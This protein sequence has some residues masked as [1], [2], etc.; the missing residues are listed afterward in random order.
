MRRRGV[1]LWTIDERRVG[2]DG[3]GAGL[4]RGE[5]DVEG[6]ARR[7]RRRSSADRAGRRGR[8]RRVRPPGS[9]GRAPAA[10]GSWPSASRSATEKAALEDRPAPTGR[11]L[12]T[13]TVPPARRSAGAAGAR[14]PGRPRGNR[15]GVVAQGD[16]QRPA[17]ELVRV[18]PDQEAAG[19]RREGDLG[20]QV[21]GHR[22][23]EAAVV[24]GV[25]ADD[26]H[27]SGGTGRRHH[28][29]LAQA[30]RLDRRGRLGSRSCDD[31]PQWTAE[32]DQDHRAGRDRAGALHLHDA[33]R[34]R[35]AGPAPRAG[36]AGRGRAGRGAP[37]VG[38]GP[39]LGPVEPVTAV[40]RDRPQEPRRRRARARPGRAGGRADRG[41]PARCGRAARGRARGVLRPQPPAR[42]RPHD[43]LGPGRAHGARWPATT[44]TTSRSA[45]PCGR[46]GGPTRRRSRR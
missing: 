29:S 28:P 10:S 41:V 13:R 20:G 15:G 38:C 33:G 3:D 5:V 27:S 25:V 11:V 19:L 24:V 21:D 40:G 22:Q 9:R 39:L 37:G 8:P 4:E 46:S 7:W 18:D 12:V 6:V 42:L 31:R 2:G 45:A 32:R 30:G 16:L 1:S 44:S 43:G 35:G 26:G 14:P 17:G 34:R 23:R 36:R